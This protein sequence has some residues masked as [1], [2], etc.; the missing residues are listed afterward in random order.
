M[1]KLKLLRRLILLLI[2]FGL[3]F[4]GFYTYAL[5]PKDYTFSRYEYVHKNINSKLNGFKIAF[6]TD[7]HL[8]DKNNLERFQEMI[9]KLN[10]YPFDMVIFGGDL[11]DG[12]V[13][14]A[15]EVSSALKNIDCKYG[16]F[17]V[18]GE[19]D[20]KSSLEVTQVLNDG[21][22]EVIENEIRTIYYKDTS[23]LLLA[24]D[25]QT[26]ISTLKGD[27]Q[28]IKIA[29]AHQ[30]DTFSQNQGKIN[31]QLSGHS[32]GGSIYIPYYGP[33]MTIDGAKTYNHGIYQ[34]S[35]ST[36]LVSNGFSG[37]SSFPYKFFARNEIN[38]ITLSSSSSS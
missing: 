3:F 24:T 30:P 37:P 8:S 10:D 25:D 38:I 21:G 17:A 36:L 12:H 33:L 14:S 20:K 23:F 27:T 32:G 22:F 15:K 34:N 6:I 13:F 9:T 16:K 2:V 28:T 7:I 1:K 19:N 35:G 26:D 5:S 11:Y 4:I 18:L 31:F 29:I